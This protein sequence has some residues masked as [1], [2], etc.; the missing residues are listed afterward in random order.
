M[1]Q[2]PNHEYNV[3]NEGASDWHVPL[4]ENFEALERD[5]EIRDTAANRS[6]YEPTSGARFLATD[7][8]EVSLGDGSNWQP[9]A[10]TGPEPTLEAITAASSV[11]DLVGGLTV[12]PDSNTA[13]GVRSETSTPSG[14]GVEGIATSGG[15]GI[16]A[17]DRDGTG[18]ALEA[19]GD[20]AIEG[21]LALDGNIATLRDFVGIN[22][23]EA[24]TSYESFGLGVDTDSWGGMYIQTSGSNGRPFYG[25]AH[26]G[27]NS[28][29]HEYDLADDTWRLYIAG[30][31]VM[32]VDGDGNLSTTGN[33]NFVE[34]V[35]TPDGEKE[36]VYTATEAGTPHTEASG[37]AELQDGR[38]EV[39]LPEHFG[40]VTSEAEPLVVQVTPHAGEPVSPQVTD[41]STGR[42]VVE[43]FG[44][45]T[46]SYEVSYTVRGT[47]E[48][49]GDKRVVRNPTGEKTERRSHA[50]ADD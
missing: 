34:T 39:E 27:G 46:G 44:D 18:I 5:V 25:Y 12:S 49:H 7:T 8:G 1:P 15:T 35:E 30:S 33:K 28:A 48:G 21:E 16:R 42:I 40:W 10:T 24:F 36:V 47:R 14:V 17:D 26:P 37:V 2:T 3:P 6:N 11:L 32:D 13:H 45:G 41:R 9:I 29:Y 22:R 19:S 38:A 23:E 31:Y 43:D 50:S 4:N 20:T